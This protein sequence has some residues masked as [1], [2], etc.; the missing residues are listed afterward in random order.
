MVKL[1]WNLNV[2]DWIA[3]G[4]DN[5]GDGQNAENSGGGDVGTTDFAVVFFDWIVNF[6]EREGSDGENEGKLGDLDTGGGNK[7]DGIKNR[8]SAGK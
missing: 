1:K 3:K 2:E 4:N 8:P 7:F 6:E 5:D